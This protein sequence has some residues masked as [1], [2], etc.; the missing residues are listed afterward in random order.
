M[1]VKLKARSFPRALFKL[2]ELGA[3]LEYDIDFQVVG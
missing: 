3:N 1:T 2:N